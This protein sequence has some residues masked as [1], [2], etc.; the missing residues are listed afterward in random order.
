[1]KA[2]LEPDSS[3]DKSEMDAERDLEGSPKGTKRKASR[4]VVNSLKKPSLQS[5]TAQAWWGF[6]VLGLNTSRRFTTRIGV[7]RNP[8][9]KEVLERLRVDALNF[10]L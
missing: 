5:T 7:T 1:M 9:Q 4:P 2:F 8:L 3:R 6:L 10:V